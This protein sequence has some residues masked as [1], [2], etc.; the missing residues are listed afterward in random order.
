M[1][2]LPLTSGEMERRSLLQTS[3]PIQAISLA[4]CK[5]VCEDAAP[6]LAIELV[7]IHF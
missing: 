3:H 2:R 7:S 1:P 6:I 4:L 5:G